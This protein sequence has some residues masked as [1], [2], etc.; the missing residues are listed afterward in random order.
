MNGISALETP[1]RQ[2]AIHA[3]QARLVGD[4]GVPVMP[5]VTWSPT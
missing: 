4:D 5:P 1:I 2:V 3:N